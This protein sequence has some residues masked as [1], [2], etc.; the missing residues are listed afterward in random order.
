MEKKKGRNKKDKKNEK[1]KNFKRLMRLAE[2]TEGLETRD[3][4]KLVLFLGGIKP[5]AEV[6]LKI[7]AKNLEDKFNFEKKLKEGGVLFKAS[8]PKSYEEIKKIKGNKVIWE[9]AG[10]YYIYDLFKSKKDKEHFEEYNK[11]LE[12]GKYLL[13][14]R[15]AGKH[16]GYPSCCV[17]RFMKEKGEGFLKK[18]YNYW[19]YYKKQEELDR[20]FPFVFHR[21]CSLKCRGSRKLNKKYEEGLKRLSRKIYKEYLGE[22]RFKGKL[23]VGGYSDVEVKGK[24]I[25]PEKEGYEYELIFRKPF[26]GHYYLVSFLSRKKYEKGQVLKGEVVLKY[27]Y[28]MVRILKEKKKV[29]SGLHH[30][31]KLPLLGEVTIGM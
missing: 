27:D 9:I 23:I 26:F 21:P 29:I 28:A 31:R 5:N 18:K 13:G 10:S 6:I 15:L 20:K 17:E 24:S 14:D 16:Y 11:L 30:E 1:D 7:G 12:K 2:R 19:G 4:I 3:K 8:S 25:W 22:S